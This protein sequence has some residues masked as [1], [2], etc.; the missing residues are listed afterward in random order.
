[1]NVC[2]YVNTFLVTRLVCEQPLKLLHKAVYTISG[3]STR[4]TAYQQ[5]AD[6]TVLFRGYIPATC[7]RYVHTQYVH[8]IIPNTICT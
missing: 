4:V 2:T 8:S 3:Y 5:G 7:T 6:G 1:M